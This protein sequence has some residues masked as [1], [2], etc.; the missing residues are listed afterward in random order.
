VLVRNLILCIEWAGSEC[1]VFRREF[2]R[3]K[4][5]VHLLL[6]D[7]ALSGGCDGDHEEREMHRERKT[8]KH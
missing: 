2:S 6:V 1:M 4:W 5:A 3:H 7:S 8:S